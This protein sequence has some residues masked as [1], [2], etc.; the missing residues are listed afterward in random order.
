[1]RRRGRGLWREHSDFLPF[2]EAD[3]IC[4]HHQ[5]VVHVTPDHHTDP[6]GASLG[7]SPR[8]SRI[9]STPLLWTPRESIQDFNAP[10]PRLVRR[11]ADAEVRVAFAERV[12]GERK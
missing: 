4:Q 7:S 12:A 5:T 11:E 6:S 8:I 9:I 3:A 10:L 2:R 1:M